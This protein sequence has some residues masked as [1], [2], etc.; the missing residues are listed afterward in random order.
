MR[1]TSAMPDDTAASATSSRAVTGSPSSA[2][3]ASSPK[4]GV[5]SVNADTR[6]AGWTLGAE[7]L[8]SSKRYDNAANTNVLGGYGL[9]NLYASTTVAREWQLLARIDNLGD[10]AYQ[11]ARGYATPGRSFYVGLRWSPK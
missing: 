3:P 6:V 2:T 10:K 4:T 8:A 1:L 7:C 5:S 9:V 11:L